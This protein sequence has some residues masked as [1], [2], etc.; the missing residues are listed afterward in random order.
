MDSVWRF[1]HFLLAVS[2]MANMFFI[3]ISGYQA[4]EQLKLS[5]T[6]LLSRAGVGRGLKINPFF[7]LFFF[8]FPH[9]GN[10]WRKLTFVKRQVDDEQRSQNQK[11]DFPGPLLCPI[12]YLR[13]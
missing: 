9:T 10:H 2:G 8:F 6:H 5:K 1:K 13:I 7:F 3:K 11:V 12:M 4:Y